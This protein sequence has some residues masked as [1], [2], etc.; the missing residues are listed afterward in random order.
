MWNSEWL[1]GDRNPRGCRLDVINN[2]AGQVQFAGLTYAG[3]FQI[4]VT[5]PPSTPGGDQPIVAMI[6]SVTSPSTTVI[7]VQ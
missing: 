7:A 1:S 2:A 4:N 5:I 6:G 3:L